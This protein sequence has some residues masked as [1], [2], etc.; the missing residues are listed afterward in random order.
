MMKKVNIIA[1][2]TVS[3]YML[4][5]ASVWEG[6]ASIEENFPE[7]G[8][9]LATNHFP[10]NTLVEVVNLESNKSATLIVY[11]PLDNSR[12]L[13]VLS[14]EAAASIG[15]TD[16]G[17]IRMKEKD[18]QISYSSLG[19][20]KVYSGDFDYTSDLDGYDLSLV[21]A[22]SRPPEDSRG[23]DPG[24]FIPSIPNVDIPPL[25]FTDIPIIPAIPEQL[26]PPPVAASAT[27]PRFSAPMI[28]S[29]EKGS[30]YV[31]IGAYEKTQTVESE[32]QKIDK[33]LPV[34][35]METV[36]VT[37]NTEKLV[38]RVLIGPLNLGDSGA[39][40]QKYR[41]IYKDAFLR[42]GT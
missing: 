4:V 13:A 16:L 22:D 42:I 32:L 38:Y 30:Y 33:N 24:S 34:A 18:D 8:P 14:R 11:A 12:L 5:S 26:A 35:V 19:E 29:F 25:V 15:L 31:Q 28:Q 27:T 1:V 39:V 10:K 21:P 9:Y 23:P 41:A 17:R 40:F 37:G 3:I 6:T 2:I 20:R 36:M 7:N